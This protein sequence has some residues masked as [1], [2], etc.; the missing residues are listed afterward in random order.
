MPGGKLGLPI[1]V[2]LKLAFGKIVEPVLTQR[3]IRT[4]MKG[5]ARRC[6]QARRRDPH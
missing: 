4:P 1:V 2:E 5:M 6:R 3:L